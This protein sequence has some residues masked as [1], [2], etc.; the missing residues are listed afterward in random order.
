MDCL[1]RAVWI[2]AKVDK[3][4]CLHSALCLIAES[5]QADKQVAVAVARK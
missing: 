3:Q 4:T 1:E 2:P 5:R